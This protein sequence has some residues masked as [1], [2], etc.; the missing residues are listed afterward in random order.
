MQVKQITV[1]LPNI[2]GSL[3]HVTRLLAAARV[4]IEAMSVVD[5]TDVGLVRLVARNT[6]AASKA[7]TKAGLGF[8]VQNVEI[9]AI[10]DRIGSLAT[11]A[12]KL[13]QGGVSIHYIYGTTCT[14]GGACDCRLVISASDLKK[15]RMLAAK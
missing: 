5:T 8:T 10:T 6:Q 2:K 3:A 11:L 1:C 13:A 14:C 7:L 12:G 9:L 4:D 15:V